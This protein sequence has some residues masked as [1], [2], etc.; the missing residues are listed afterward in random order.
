MADDKVRMALLIWVVSSAFYSG[1]RVGWDH[2]LA[3]RGFAVLAVL[4]S[5]VA[6]LILWLVSH[7]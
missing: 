7:G 4:A 3:W 1:V 2:S 5:A 6:T